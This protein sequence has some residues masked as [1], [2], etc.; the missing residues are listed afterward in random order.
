GNNQ[1]VELPTSI[2]SL[3]SLKYLFLRSNLLS[4]LEFLGS[5]PKLKYLNLE[6]N[7][8]ASYP[9][10]LNKLEDRGVKVFK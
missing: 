6:K 2:G 4:K 1:I 10:F 9:D 8:M 3:K 5:L 7:K